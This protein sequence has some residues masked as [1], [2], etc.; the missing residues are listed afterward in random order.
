[1]L[2]ESRAAT[3]A[4]RFF[5]FP[6][7]ELELFFVRACFVL[8][9]GEQPATGSILCPCKSSTRSPLVKT[10]EQQISLQSSQRWAVIIQAITT[11]TKQP[12]I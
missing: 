5:Q 2:A 7:N 8:V 6:V 3:V 1:M 4:Y 11:A 10:S 9:E 12:G